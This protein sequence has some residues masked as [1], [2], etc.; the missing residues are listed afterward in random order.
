MIEKNLVKKVTLNIKTFL[1]NNTVPMLFSVIIILGMF[2]TDKTPYFLMNEIVQLSLRNAFLVLA[3]LIPVRMGMGLNFSIVIGAMAGQLGVIVAIDKGFIGFQSF[4]I[5][6]AFSTPLAIFLGFITGKLLNKAR[7]HEMIASLFLSYFMNGIYQIFCLFLIGRIIPLKSK[8]LLLSSGVGLRNTLD[9]SGNLKG[10][11]DAIFGGRL[12]VPIFSVLF[13]FGIIA[14]V[15]NFYLLSRG[16]TNTERSKLIKLIAVTTVLGLFSFIVM[17]TD[18]LPSNLSLIRNVKLSLATGTLLF[19][20][21]VFNQLFTK[22]KFVES[23]QII[24]QEYKNEKNVAYQADKYRVVSIMISIVL[25]AWGQIIYLQSNGILITYGSHMGVGRLAV[26]ALIIGGASIKRATVGQA[27][28]GIV[29]LQSFVIL[30]PS[31]FDSIF[32]E[33]NLFEVL[34]TLILNGVIL[35]AFIQTRRSIEG[36]IATNK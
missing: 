30:S 33:R 24:S 23:F 4:L 17:H 3:I 12:Q 13:A 20:F 27:L 35:Y 1:S 29:L 19:V 15:I 11:V 32:E 25:A 16:S 2:T 21:I 9:L 36:N 10:S 18:L 22:A 8:E 14:S 7:G 28:L 31:L 26:I 5:A 6:V 34:R